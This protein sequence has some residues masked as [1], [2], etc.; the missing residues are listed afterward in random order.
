M[1][2]KEKREKYKNY[3]L[4]EILKNQLEQTVENLKNLYSYFEKNQDLKIK[5]SFISTLPNENFFSSIRYRERRPTAHSY[6][7]L[8]NSSIIEHVIKFCKGRG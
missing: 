4:P 1:L 7:A 6:A 2:T 8:F 5:L 3:G